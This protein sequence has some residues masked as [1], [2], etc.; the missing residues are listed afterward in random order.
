MAV[1]LCTLTATEIMEV[2]M[3]IT[4]KVLWIL[5]N[6][7]FNN[8]LE[9]FRNVM[10]PNK[11]SSSQ[12]RRSSQDDFDQSYSTSI[13]DSSCYSNVIQEVELLKQKLNEMEEELSAIKQ[14]R[15]LE[16]EMKLPIMINVEELHKFMTTKFSFFIGKAIESTSPWLSDFRSTILSFIF[17]QNLLV[18]LMFRADALSV[19]GHSIKDNPSEFNRMMK[20]IQEIHVSKSL[21][22]RDFLGFLQK[23]W[24]YLPEYISKD[25]PF[26]CSFPTTTQLPQY[27]IGE[28]NAVGLI[29]Y[30]ATFIA[31]YLNAIDT[32]PEDIHSSILQDR[33][34]F[35]IDFITILLSDQFTNKRFYASNKEKKKH[36]RKDKKKTKVYPKI[37]GLNDAFIIKQTNDELEGK[38]F[39]I[40]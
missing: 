1:L 9:D 26:E 30:I 40:Y 32:F 4:L 17:N 31:N 8:H 27:W 36:S 25:D 6:L 2:R 16:T 20:A 21:Y 22:R 10:Y 7:Y 38:Y 3:I 12:D 5:N 28:K 14:T 37:Y 13:S 39:I 19:N 34:A 23:C 11:A 35:Q 33:P 18:L 24:K 29:K 15:K